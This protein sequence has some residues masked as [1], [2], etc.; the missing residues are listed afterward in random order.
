MRLLLARQP[1]QRGIEIVLIE[2]LHPHH[3]GH[4]VLLRPAHRRQPRPAMGDARQDQEQGK[5]ALRSAAQHRREA[6]LVG[7]LLERK[8][9]PENLATGDL[10]HLARPVIEFALHQALHGHDP[11]RGP[12]R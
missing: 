3:I 12:M 4:G 8:Q 6:Y 5:L 1:V 7:Q 10:A 11:L 2:P 9:H